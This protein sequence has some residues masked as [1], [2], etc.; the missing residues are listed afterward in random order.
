MWKRFLCK[1]NLL[2][3]GSIIILIPIISYCSVQVSVMFGK[4]IDN[5]SDEYK[6]IKYV[7]MFG[8]TSLLV[9]ICEK[10]LL[11][12]LEERLATN[13]LLTLHQLIVDKVSSIEYER[14]IQWN[15]IELFQMCSRDIYDVKN[16]SFNSII[17]FLMGTITGIL[18]IIELTKI[19]Y[20]FPI[21]AGV[22]Y[23][24]AL[25][26][27]KPLGKISK[28]VS[29]NLRDSE[30]FVTSS[31]MGILSCFEVIK[32]FGRSDTEICKF[33]KANEQYNANVIKSKIAINFYK[34][35]NRVINAI[36]PVAIV[37]VGSLHYK[38]GNIT[39][40]QMITAIGLL[41]SICYPIQS[42]GEIFIQAKNSWFKI[43]NIISFLGEL[44]EILL[45][46]IHENEFCGDIK[47]ENVYYKSGIN[48]ILNN[49]SFKIPY[50]KKTA[51]IGQTGSGKSTIAN[52][53]S[54]LI[55]ESAGSIF[56]GDI[57]ICDKNRA[58]LRRSISYVHSA[59]FLINDT[60]NKNLEL[61]IPE[62]EKLESIIELLGIRKI[63]DS[64]SNG[65][66]TILGT[67]GHPLSS[68]QE[69]RIGLARGLSMNR[70]YYL[71][72]EVT[73][74]LD[75]EAAEQVINLINENMNEKTIIL[76]TH[77][78]SKMKEFDHIIMVNNGYVCGE[79]KHMELYQMCKD[80]RELY[81]G[82]RE[83]KV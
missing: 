2:Y 31:F 57:E 25:L 67:G 17:K 5:F 47:F 72:D 48:Y 4:T 68:G 15:K 23:V 62:K 79:G 6:F 53:I 41:A 24:S 66:M 61:G 7:I 29:N 30:K 75:E 55:R 20:I 71:L 19:Y 9:Y 49:I 50:G 60:L 44:D 37:L 80:Y 63:A 54:G 52:L 73:T 83:R 69:K 16:F 8:I 59:T 39:I 3:L 81:N 14:F 70:N 1:R 51:I 77:D 58:A 33:E 64:L 26:I 46:N 34:T 35:L 12:L 38:N 27:V 32:A 74:G 65:F 28:K 42:F 45:Y 76:I 36:A 56:F 22:I 11:L 10:I 40:G 43:A 18:A 21:I 82:K 13:F 78:L